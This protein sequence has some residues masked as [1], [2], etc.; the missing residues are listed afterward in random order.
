LRSYRKTRFAVDPGGFEVKTEGGADYREEKI[1]LPPSW[2]RGFM[3]LQ[4]A[5]SFPIRRVPV[6]REGLYAILAHLKKKNRARKSPRAVRFELTPGRPVEIVLEP[7]ELRVKLHDK[8]YEGGD[9]G[10]DPHLGPRSVADARAAVADRGRGGGVHARH[11]LAEFL[12]REARR[13]AIAAR[14]LGVDGERLDEWW[15]GAGRSRAAGRT[16]RG[17]SGRRGERLPTHADADVRAGAAADGRGP[18]SGRGGAQPLRP[19]GGNS[20]TT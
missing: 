16:E 6:S 12:E 20:F 14:P 5:M 11:G 18:G 17:R 2:L 3:Q 8:P 4:A 1:D 10:D 19:D 9:G 13:D 15:R 7:W